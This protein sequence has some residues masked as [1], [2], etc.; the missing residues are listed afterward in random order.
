V[1][2]IIWL[3]LRQDTTAGRSVA[4]ASNVT[5]VDGGIPIVSTLAGNVSW[6]QLI[7]TDDGA[8]WI[9]SL[10]PDIGNLTQSQADGR[11]VRTINN[12]GPDGS[13]NVAIA[14]TTGFGNGIGDVDMGS[15][16]G[17]TIDPRFASSTR[18]MVAGVLYCVKARV[19]PSVTIGNLVYPGSGVGVVTAGCFFNVYDLNGNLLGGTGDVSG[20][21][22]FGSTGQTFAFT[23]PFTTGSSSTSVIITVLIVTASTLPTLVS[24]PAVNLGLTLGQSGSNGYPYFA[25]GT[26]L[27]A[28][29]GSLTLSYANCT[30]GAPALSAALF[31]LT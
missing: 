4:F 18:V 11:Y 22:P 24:G 6:I 5:G 30:I 13:G 12:V 9:A 31:G 28:P 25:Y 16:K 8:T 7:S 27:S 17:L 2:S 29:P 26:G 1:A 10:G 21:G 15:L 23:T 3:T 14:A 20:S 19:L